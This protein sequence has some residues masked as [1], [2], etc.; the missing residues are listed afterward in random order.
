MEQRAKITVRGTRTAGGEAP[1][2]MELVSFGTLCREEETLCLRYE[3]TELTGLSGTTTE[4]RIAADGSVT[5]TRTGSLNMQ[6][7]FEVGREDRTLY[8]LGFGALM[9]TMRTEKI[10]SQWNE[11]GGFLS[12]FYHVSIEDEATG[13]FECRIEAEVQ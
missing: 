10:E 8:D 4:V 1:E 12:I 5:L 3:E 9:L 2:T 11:R 13:S 7:V 6:M